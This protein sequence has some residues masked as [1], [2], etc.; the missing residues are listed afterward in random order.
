MGDCPV[1]MITTG[2]HMG[3]MTTITTTTVRED[4]ADFARACPIQHQIGADERSDLRQL[5]YS[6]SFSNYLLL[7]QN[8]MTGYD[9]DY[10]YDYR[11]R[12][13]GRFRQG[14]IMTT[15]NWGR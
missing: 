14:M 8:T 11:P 15:P 6:S 10:Y 9:D 12:R 4:L 13:F 7:I 5:P 1:M 3:M 2:I